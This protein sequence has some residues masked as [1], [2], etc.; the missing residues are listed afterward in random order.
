MGH[1]SPVH[2]DLGAKLQGRTCAR[3]VKRF[4]DVIQDHR[5]WTQLSRKAAL[6]SEAQGKIELAHIVQHSRDR[7]CFFLTVSHRL[8]VFRNRGPGVLAT[9]S[10]LKGGGTG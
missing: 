1:R 4:H 2:P 10:E 7:R 9:G 6:S 5:Q 3:I 8:L